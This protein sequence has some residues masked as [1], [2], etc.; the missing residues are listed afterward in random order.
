MKKIINFTL[1]IMMVAPMSLSAHP[2]H[3]HENPLSPGHY[4]ANPEHAIPLLL[5]FLACVAAAWLFNRVADRLTD[6]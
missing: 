3:G 6:K 4:V 2:G 1:A 5:T